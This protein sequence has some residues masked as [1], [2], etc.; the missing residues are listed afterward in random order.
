MFYEG[1]KTL[2]LHFV[3]FLLNK[4]LTNVL[5]EEELRIKNKE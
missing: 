4:C 3:F 2:T 5:P 1:A